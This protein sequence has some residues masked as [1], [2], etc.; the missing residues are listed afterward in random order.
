MAHI[1]R[2]LGILRKNVQY[3]VY[4]LVQ[5]EGFDESQNTWELKE[6]LLADSDDTVKAMISDFEAQVA[7]SVLPHTRT[8]L[9]T[10]TSNLHG[11]VN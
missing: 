2:S 8:C 6:S 7:I 4:Y 9:S 1:Y 3:E 11:T 10:F 5:W